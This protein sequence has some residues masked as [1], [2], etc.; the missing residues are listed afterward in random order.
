MIKARNINRR[1]ENNPDK[2]IYLLNWLLKLQLN[3]GDKKKVL[4]FSGNI[5]YLSNVQYM[6][7]NFR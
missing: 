5:A 7:C 6:L 2:K 3:L 4:F 1:Y